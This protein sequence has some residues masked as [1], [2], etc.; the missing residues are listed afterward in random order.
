MLINFKY[1][2]TRRVPYNKIEIVAGFMD[3][4][5]AVKFAE[6]YSE[7]LISEDYTRAFTVAVTDI[8]CEKRIRIAQIQ[9]P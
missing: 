8:T 7:N 5:T 3:T 9:H 1:V 6:T 4:Q 2:V